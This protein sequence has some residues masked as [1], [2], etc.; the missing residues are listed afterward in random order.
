MTELS[1]MKWAYA[2]QMYPEDKFW[3]QHDCQWYHQ[4]REKCHATSLPTIYDKTKV[5]VGAG[6]QVLADA[7][8]RREKSW[9]RRNFDG[10]FDAA[11]AIHTVWS[12]VRSRAWRLERSSAW[13]DWPER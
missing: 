3:D 5:D 9:M 11:A 6:R 1:G 10:A 12:S 7:I 2:H 13:N 4:L 8:V